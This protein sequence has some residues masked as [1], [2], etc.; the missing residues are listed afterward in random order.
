MMKRIIGAGLLLALA[1]CGSKL[2]PEF[3]ALPGMNNYVMIIPEGTDPASL[4]ALAKAHCG[5][6]AQ[7]SV[8]GWRDK[9]SA[10]TALPMTDRELASELFAYDINRTSGLDRA[11]WNCKVY[12]RNDKS[13]CLAS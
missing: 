3:H 9:T 5:T 8:Y 4:P 7:C 11:L 12:P 1:A 2:E 13:E 6:A 10:P